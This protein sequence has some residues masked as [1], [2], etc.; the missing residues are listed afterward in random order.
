MFPFLS[1]D[2][3]FSISY[4]WFTTIVCTAPSSA[5][6]PTPHPARMLIP[7]YM[8]PFFV[9]SAQPTSPYLV[10]PTM[11]SLATCFAR[12]MSSWLVTMFSVLLLLLIKLVR[13][14]E[15]I[16]YGRACYCS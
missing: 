13:L 9:T 4:S 10:S 14:S 7:V 11:F 2:T 16:Y 3:S 1:M 8:L 15:S 6:K 5:Q 12:C